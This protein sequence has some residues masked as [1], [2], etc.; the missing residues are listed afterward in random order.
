MRQDRSGA[1]GTGF[2]SLELGPELGRGLPRRLPGGR[3]GDGGAAPRRRCRRRGILCRHR[4]PARR[5]ARRRCRAPGRAPVSPAILSHFPF[6]AAPHRERSCRPPARARPGPSPR[7]ARSR[8]QRTCRAAGAG[9]ACLPRR[10]R[11]K[12]SG[13]G[14]CSCSL[15]TP[16]PRRGPTA[17][18]PREGPCRPRPPPRPPAG[19]RA[20][21]AGPTAGAWAGA[22]VETPRAPAGLS[23]RHPSRLSGFPC[24]RPLG[25]ERGG[26]V[27]GG[28]R[29]R[30][31][32]EGVGRRGEERG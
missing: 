32:A 11:N 26:H 30:P 18:G 23:Q 5:P 2:R 14:S 29:V 15:G 16:R 19:P 20:L 13:G 4:P 10:A 12:G 1:G 6:S 7:L 28:G 17:G 27:V 25:R 22:A 31:G 24:A 9:A 8:P 3:W 21:T